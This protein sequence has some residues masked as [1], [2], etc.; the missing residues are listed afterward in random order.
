VDAVSWHNL[1]ALKRAAAESYPYLPARTW[2]TA[3]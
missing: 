1:F 2:T 3:G